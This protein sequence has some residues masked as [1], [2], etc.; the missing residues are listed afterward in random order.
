MQVY[1]LT[2]PAYIIPPISVW[3]SEPVK[4]EF[5]DQHQQAMDAEIKRNYIGKSAAVD[6][7]TG[8]TKFAP[9]I[10][11]FLQKCNP[12]RSI[13][14]PAKWLS[15]WEVFSYTIFPHFTAKAEVKLAN[16]TQQIKAKNPESMTKGQVKNFHIRSFHIG[17]NSGNANDVMGQIVKR[18]SFTTAVQVEWGWI[19]NHST[20]ETPESAIKYKSHWMVGVDGTGACH[21]SNLRA[22]RNR[23]LVDLKK[24]DV[25]TSS[26]PDEAAG[27]I[28]FA[29]VNLD[30]GGCAIIN[31]LNFTETKLIT[32]VHLFTNCFEKSTV[33]HTTAGD[34]IYLCGMKYLAN[35]I[36]KHK[37]LLFN[38]L[39]KMP[40]MSLYTQQFY[41][42]DTIS[43][44][45]ATLRK[46]Q[47]EIFTERVNK[48]TS[49]LATYSAISSSAAA[50]IFGHNENETICAKYPDISHE[51]SQMT[52]LDTIR[53]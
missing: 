22:W 12:L 19:A 13:N 17:D 50:R 31:V 28:V 4:L 53:Q 33:I 23:M 21:A 27:A 35:I 1:S 26:S 52:G 42:S 6:I 15:L 44:F 29:L 10:A 9:E 43:G 14:T 5:T 16:R 51:W 11:T 20:E 49:L 3:V 37:K 39:D 36:T 45:M 24:L 7:I 38:F 32:L 30:A 2:P 48:Y 18:I 34:E 47:D 40:N 46:I 25:V 41:E 8:A